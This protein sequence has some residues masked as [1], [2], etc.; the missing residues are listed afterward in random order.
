MRIVSL[1]PSLTELAFD[2]GRGDDVLGVTR[3][4]V[5]VGPVHP[6]RSEDGHSG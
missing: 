4:C 2:L 1:C 5:H 6:G 3:Y